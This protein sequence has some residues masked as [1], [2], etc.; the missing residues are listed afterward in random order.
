MKPIR[1]LLVFAAAISF[2]GCSYIQSITGSSEQPEPKKTQAASEQPAPPKREGVMLTWEVPSEPVDGFLIRYGTKRN[3]LDKE[4]K[5]KTNELH[6]EQDP[7][8]GPVYHYTVPDVPTGKSI[9]AAIAAFKGDRI[10]DFSE[11]M[12]ARGGE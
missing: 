2:A 8:Y 5:V 3:E 7:E 10:S 6:Q 11:A 1:H 9:F 12:P 4:V